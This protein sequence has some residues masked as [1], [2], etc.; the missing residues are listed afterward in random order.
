[1]GPPLV[2]EGL[3]IRAVGDRWWIVWLIQPCINFI[4][5]DRVKLHGSSSMRFFGT[6]LA[7]NNLGGDAFCRSPRSG[8]QASLCRPRCQSLRETGWIETGFLEIMSLAP[9]GLPGGACTD[10]MVS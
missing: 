7:V 9:T 4:I 6:Q 1:H 5:G 8:Q 2:G 10:K 3:V